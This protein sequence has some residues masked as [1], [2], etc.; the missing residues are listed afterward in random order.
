MNGTQ[1]VLDLLA[2]TPFGGASD[3]ALQHIAPLFVTRHVSKGAVVFSEGELEGG[4]FVIGEGCLKAFRNL[5]DGHEITVFILGAG[6]FFGFLP[7]LD[8]GPLPVSVSALAPARIHVLNREDFVRA[9]MGSPELCLLLLKYMAQRLRGCFDRVGLLGRQNAITRT[10]HALL[11]LLPQDRACSGR[12]ELELTSSQAEMAKTLN[13]TAENL[14]RA[15]A[16]LCRDGTI[17]RLGR[18]RFRVHDIKALANLA[19]LV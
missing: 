1:H 12:L 3:A 4:F 8:Q 5:P 13:V 9:V 2:R 18:R 6:D 11:S 10:A 17:E 19:G 7:L 16:R 14:S 15:L